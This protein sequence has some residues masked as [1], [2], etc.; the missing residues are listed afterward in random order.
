M[1][2]KPN[3]SYHKLVQRQLKKHASEEL[4]ANEQFLHFI[5][6]VSDSYEAF[7]K[8]KE[9]SDHSFTISQQ[10]FSEINDK[11]KEEFELKNIF[12]KKLKDA[13][14]NISTKANNAFIHQDDDL[15]QIVDLLN[16]EITKR[17]EVESQLLLAKDEAEQASHAKSEFL[18]IMS[19]EIRTPLNAVIGMGHL[20]LKHN[21][22]EDQ[23]ANLTALKTSADHLL[24]LINDILDF[25]KI[26]SG[27]LELEESVFNIKK[28]ITDIITGNKNSAD[29]RE[30]K[31]VLDIDTRLSH[32]YL[33]DGLRLGQVFNNLISNAVKFTQKGTI[34][35]SAKLKN[36]LPNNY[37]QIDFAIS[38]SGV[39][40]LSDKLN[41]IF[42]P[43]M[44]A[45][46]S[47]T[48]KYGGTGLGLAITK[49]ILGLLG[50]DIKVTS[51][52]GSGSVFYFT[53][54]LKIVE[55]D[56][57]TVAAED[58]IDFDLR[59]KR[60]LLVEDTL[61]NILFATQ[62]LEGWNAK[63]DVAENGLLA[64]EKL[65][66]ASYDLVL[67]DL[68][69]PVMDGYTATHKIREFNNTIPIIALTASATTN[70][71]EKVMA[72][73]MQDYVT[74]PFNPNDFYLK[75]K[76]HLGF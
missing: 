47:I 42:M 56:E 16:D 62:L 76:R 60:I 52:V 40:I 53:L 8:D 18:S 51:Q 28:L 65:Q 7:D 22:R 63:I 71:R 36:K 38:D 4:L 58:V 2:P 39:G 1:Q 19:H 3:Q 17:K 44:Q 29:E 75:L 26:E 69:M 72:V 34:T 5:D 32:H 61:F 27:K 24:V 73:G 23:I 10:D 20:L 46:T 50:S 74:K 35:V 14:N 41:A 31:I 11:L 6:A 55:I 48:R 43:F 67:M 70:V 68:Q 9:L 45:S 64:T 25:N 15:L 12:I 49:R 57:N 59:G 21:P 13:L 33:G 66:Q 54:Q 30:N 37:A